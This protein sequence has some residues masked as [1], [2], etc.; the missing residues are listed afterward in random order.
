MYLLTNLPYSYSVANIGLLTVTI[1]PAPVS[2]DV[3]SIS[4]VSNVVISN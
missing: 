3:K 2:K 1:N 4:D